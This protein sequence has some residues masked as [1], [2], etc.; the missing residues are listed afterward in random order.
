MP[1][2][3]QGSGMGQEPR[4]AHTHL[5]A[6]F[7]GRKPAPGAAWPQTPLDALLPSVG[8]RPVPKVGWQCWTWQCPWWDAWVHVDACMPVHLHVAVS[9]HVYV[10]VCTCVHVSAFVCARVSMG[11]HVCAQM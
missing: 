11:M 10:H 6:A 2:S 8:H 5:G 1:W 9:G 3:W 4:G 7:H